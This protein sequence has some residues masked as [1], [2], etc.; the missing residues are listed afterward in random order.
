MC[1]CL[2]TLIL[3]HVVERMVALTLLFV[4]GKGWIGGVLGAEMGLYLLYK[5]LRA[6]FIVCGY[7]ARGMVHRL[8]TALCR[9]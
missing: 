4:T 8:S 6:D 2:F 5:A 7:L 1:A 3:A 9:S